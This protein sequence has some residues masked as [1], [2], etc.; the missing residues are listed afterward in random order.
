M[1]L[2]RDVIY[3]KYPSKDHASFKAVDFNAMADSVIPITIV[4]NGGKADISVF[5]RSKYDIDVIRNLSE[6]QGG[7]MST[8]NIRFKAEN[9]R[10]YNY[11]WLVDLSIRLISSSLVM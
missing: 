6:I 10:N 11:Y 3:R 5:R 2:K 7:W 1:V 4:C 8:Q 9:D